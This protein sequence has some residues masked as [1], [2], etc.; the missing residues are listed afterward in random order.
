[1]ELRFEELGLERAGFEVG[2]GAVFGVGFRVEVGIEQS[3]GLARVGIRVRQK[4]V[5]VRV[6]MGESWG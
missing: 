4:G 5:R 1:M 2:A 3:Y 6:W